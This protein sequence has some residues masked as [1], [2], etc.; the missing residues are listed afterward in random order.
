MK[1]YFVKTVFVLFSV[2]LMAGC[3]P[4]KT[5]GGGTD[6]KATVKAEK[7]NIIA[8][9]NLTSNPL[10]IIARERGYFAEEGIDPNFIFLRDGRTE[11]LSTGKG[12]IYLQE[13]IPPLVYASQGAPVKIIGGTLSGGNY[14]ICKAENAEKYATLEGWKGARLGTVRLSTS[15]MVSR[16]AIT[17]AGLDTETDVRYTE[18]DSYPNIIEAVRKGQV[19]IGFIA[20]GPYRQSA[21]DLGLFILFPMNFLTPNYLC[22]R[23]NAYTPSLEAKRELFV[24]FLVA[25]LRAWKDFNDINQREDIIKMFATLTSQTEAFITEMVFDP[26]RNGERSYNPDPD[27]RRVTNVWNTLKVTGYIKPEGIE[28]ENVVDVTVYKDAL[29]EVRRRYP[30]EPLYEELAEFYKE[31]DE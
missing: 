10:S 19:D 13:L 5:D 6:A 21:L 12:D 1:N 18:I 14:V 7:F 29:D 25:Y 23:L 11:A 15:E 31:N 27:R 30:N 9:P 20:G 2:A 28:I 24:R 22:C 3:A 16:Y 8:D 4:K 17:Q 26:S